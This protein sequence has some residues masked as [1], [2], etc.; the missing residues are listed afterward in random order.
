M[1]RLDYCDKR[2]TK[3]TKDK[4]TKVEFRKD[5][6]QGCIICEEVELCYS[7]GSWDY[8]MLIFIQIQLK[9]PKTCCYNAM[10]GVFL[11][12]VLWIQFLSLACMYAW[13]RLM[14]RVLLLVSQ[15]ASGEKWENSGIYYHIIL[16]TS[17]CLD[18]K[19]MSKCQML[20]QEA[21]KHS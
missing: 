15:V 3:T 10:F 18:Y 5:F 21:W 9:I 19:L 7:I 12:I 16:L 20:L 6:W 2:K 1:S 8:C 4:L 11:N 14:S 17:L 13:S